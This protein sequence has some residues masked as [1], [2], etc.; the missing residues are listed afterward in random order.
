MLFN[1]LIIFILNLFVSSKVE[2][3]NEIKCGISSLN[4]FSRFD[5]LVS[6]NKFI[7]NLFNLFYT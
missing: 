4:N 6:K 3:K 2:K 5:Y 1:F 7:K